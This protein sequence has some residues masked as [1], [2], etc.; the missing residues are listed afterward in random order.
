MSPVLDEMPPSR[1]FAI[2][3]YVIFATVVLISLAIGLYHAFTGDKQR[4]TGEYLMGNRNLKTIP[5]AMSI[6]VSY[7]SSILVLGVP[8]E[9]YTRG[10]QLVLRTVGYCFA[11][12]ISSLLFVPLF[13]RLNVTSSFEVSRHQS[14]Y[15]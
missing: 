2:I 3:D 12:V 8:A 7:V 11:C 15:V 14:T 9:M 1:G 6:L 10:T 4:T 13:Y 5:V